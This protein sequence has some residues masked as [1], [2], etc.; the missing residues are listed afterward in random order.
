MSMKSK[1]KGGSVVGDEKSLTV[2]ERKLKKLHDKI[3]EGVSAERRAEVE[4]AA[5]R[6][7]SIY[8]DNIFK[9]TN[10]KGA[11]HANL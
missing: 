4:V 2:R 10:E 7:A 6:I 8:H 5:A 1:R 11:N 3:F 9:S